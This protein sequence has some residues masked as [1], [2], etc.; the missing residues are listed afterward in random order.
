MQADTHT[1]TQTRTKL[2][3][4]QGE[5]PSYKFSA[6]KYPLSTGSSNMPNTHT[7]THAFVH[8]H[9]HAEAH[10]MLSKNGT[11]ILKKNFVWRDRIWRG[12]EMRVAE[13]SEEHQQ[14]KTRRGAN[15]PSGSAFSLWATC[16]SGQQKISWHLARKGDPLLLISAEWME[17]CRNIMYSWVPGAASSWTAVCHNRMNW[18]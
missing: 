1:L 5:T 9:T 13:R 8:K 18:G 12:G 2:D 15:K 7:C 14:I 4:A 11:E 3:E 16:F 10:Q 17:S 6:S